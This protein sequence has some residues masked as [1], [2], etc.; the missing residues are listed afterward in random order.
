MD[1]SVLPLELSDLEQ[2]HCRDFFYGGCGRIHTQTLSPASTR[3][4]TPVHAECER[5]DLD[6]YSEF[7]FTLLAGSDFTIG[8]VHS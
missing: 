6:T 3:Q 8:K 7:T 1:N 2:L 4:A 5:R